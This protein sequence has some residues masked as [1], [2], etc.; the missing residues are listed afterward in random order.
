[1]LSGVTLEMYLISC[2]F[3][4]QLYVLQRGQYG[5]E[6]YLS[7]GLVLTGLVFVASFF[8]GWLIHGISAIASRG[9]RAAWNRGLQVLEAEGKNE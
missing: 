5:A 9:I 6:E 8:S 2:V 1:M 3:D 7:R 4:Q